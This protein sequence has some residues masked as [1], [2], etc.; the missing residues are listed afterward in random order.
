MKRM[1]LVI[2]L[3]LLISSSLMA[4][5][6]GLICEKKHGNGK[7]VMYFVR[8]GYAAY[9]AKDNLFRGQV[10]SGPAQ[11]VRQVDST[12]KIIVYQKD[13][14][15]GADIYTVSKRGEYIIS[16][17]TVTKGQ[18]KNDKFDERCRYLTDE[19]SESFLLMVQIDLQT[20]SDH[21]FGH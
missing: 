16:K 2:A 8:A 5:D 11:P 6:F 10:N 12:D 4:E 13:H 9:V 20:A 3:C 19:E 18:A 15:V 21:P 1:A 17:S 14:W 7:Y